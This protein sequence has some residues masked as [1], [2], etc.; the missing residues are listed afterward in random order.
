VV[1]AYPR[2]KVI[3]ASGNIVDDYHYEIDFDHAKPAVR[4]WRMMTVDHKR[5]GA[6]ELYGL[7]RTAELR[8]TPGMRTHVR[9]DSVLLARFVLLGRLRRIDDYLFFNRDHTDR[10]SKYLSRKLVRKGSRLS[11]YIGCG[12][13]PSAEWW[14]PSLKGKIVYPEWRVW[15][16]YIRAVQEAQNLT[17]AQRLAC[18][19]TI[20]QFSIRHSPKMVRDVLIACE[21]KVNLLLGIADDTNDRPTG[22]APK[23]T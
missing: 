16:E 23:A 11:K 9:G 13:V 22:I 2:T 7:I 8:K 1:L 3:D 21:Q 5:H 15:R 4:L 6:H 19:R 10:S 12:P 18:Y 17:T 20:L 14:D